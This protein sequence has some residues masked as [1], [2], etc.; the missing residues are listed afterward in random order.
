MNR[1]GFSLVEMVIVLVLAGIVSTAA[2]TMFTTSN[3]LNSTL[4]ALGESQENARSAVEVAAIELRTAAGGSVMTASASQVAV[5][6]P[7]AVGVVC[8]LRSGSRAH[9]YFPIDGSG[10][11]LRRD[12]DGKAHLTA[13]G[14]WH[15]RGMGGSD[16]FQPN[17]RQ[18]CIDNG[19]GTAGTDDNYAILRLNDPVGSPVM[20]FREVVFS[21]ARSAL[22]PDRVAFFRTTTDDRVELAQGFGSNSRFEYRLAGDTTWRATVY[23]SAL[24]QIESVRLNVSVDGDGTAGSIDAPFSLRRE[25]QLRNAL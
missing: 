8:A 6:I 4:T 21:F 23:G 17:A 14:H 7:I 12:V 25:I 16:A 1:R 2:I 5:R 9:V 15:W 10:M 3:E 13:N 19:T 24:E 22:N 18:E 11:N 20:L